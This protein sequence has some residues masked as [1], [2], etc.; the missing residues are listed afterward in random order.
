MPRSTATDLAFLRRAAELWDDDDQE[1][2][3]HPQLFCQ[4]ALP[5]QDPGELGFWERR[6]G[7][8]TLSVRPGVETDEQGRRHLAYPYGTMPRLLLSWLAT[9]AVR[10]QKPE[11]MLGANLSDFM[12]QLGM[13]P[14][15]GQTGSITRLRLQINRLFDAAIS[16]QYHGNAKVDAG[17]NL[18]V[19]TGK[20]LWW[21]ASDRNAAQCSLLPST[22][23]LSAEFY[24]HVIEHPVP[25]SLDALRALRGSPLRL[26][27]Y[28]WLTHK[29]SYTRRRTTV[30]WEQL[31]GQFGSQA[32]DSRSG[33]FKFRK[34]FERQLAAVLVVYRDANVE[35]NPTG[36]VLRP[37]QT[38]VAPR[39]SRATRIVRTNARRQRGLASVTKPRL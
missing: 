11:L 20:S 35:A 34:D 36:V 37:S 38:H 10:T 5:Y 15:G 29:M 13:R 23:W 32:A 30:S 21:S 31:R 26:D 27:I 12:S 24:N 39:P 22:V 18:T 25:V 8:V 33:R 28:A 9:E 19:A 1:I 14:T 3:Y 17:L 6:N 4:L 2:G 7:N 16:V